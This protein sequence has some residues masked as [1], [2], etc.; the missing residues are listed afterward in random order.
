MQSKDITPRNKKNQRHG[1]WERYH[2]N[3]Q[4]HDKGLWV[5]GNQVGQHLIYW[6]NG[7]LLNKSHYIDG[8]LYGYYEFNCGKHSE[9]TYHAR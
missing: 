1:Y 7:K 5:N 8:Q 4:L 3:G 6:S 9:I 2:D